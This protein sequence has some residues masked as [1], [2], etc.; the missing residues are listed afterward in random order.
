MST[1][2]DARIFINRQ[3]YNHYKHDAYKTEANISLHC[4]SSLR[5]SFR[6]DYLVD[7]R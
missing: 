5:Y 3:V 6:E 7:D 1:H 2:V 4:I